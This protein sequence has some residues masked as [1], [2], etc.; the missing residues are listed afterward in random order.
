[1][2]RK[3]I[4]ANK[5]YKLDKKTSLFLHFSS[6]HTIIISHDHLLTRDESA[7][8]LSREMWWILVL[9]MGMESLRQTGGR[10]KKIRCRRKTLC[11]SNFTQHNTS[12]HALF[13][14]VGCRR[15]GWY[16]M[17]FM[18]FFYW[19]KKEKGVRIQTT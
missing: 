9:Y 16:V 1:M 11:D 19:R 14:Y 8:A 12:H 4:K 5:K 10:R 2:L 15:M 6:S 18:C 3:N 17:H 13:R 7:V